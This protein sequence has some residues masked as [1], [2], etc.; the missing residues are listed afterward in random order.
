MRLNEVIAEL[1]SM[2]NPKAVEGMTRYGIRADRA[3]GVSIPKLEGLAKKIGKSHKLAEEIQQL[4]SKAARWVA[5]DA[6]RELRSAK[7]QKRLSGR[8]CLR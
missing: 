8:R 2:G 7:V 4:E 6:L 5:G 1:K 3:L